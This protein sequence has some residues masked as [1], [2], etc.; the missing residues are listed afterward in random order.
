MVSHLPGTPRCF[1]TRLRAQAQS[2]RHLHVRACVRPC[3]R[4]CILFRRDFAKARRGR[5]AR[6]ECRLPRGSTFA[7]SFSNTHALRQAREWGARREAPRGL[8]DRACLLGRERPAHPRGEGAPPSGE[9]ARPRASDLGL[10]DSRGGDDSALWR[11]CA[12]GRVPGASGLLPTSGAP[13]IFA[14][15]ARARWQRGPRAA[16][17]G[18]TEPTVGVQEGAPELGGGPLAPRPP[19]TR[20]WRRE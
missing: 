12:G 14:R 17:P 7:L 5:C 6:V 18:A 13:V 10:A 2:W 15:A 9:G 8:A 16:R 11:R 19:E 1:R 4:P 20:E 3:V